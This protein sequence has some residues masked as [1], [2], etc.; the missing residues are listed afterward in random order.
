MSWRT[1]LIIATCVLLHV[2][3]SKSAVIPI[4]KDGGDGSI[5][6][7]ATDKLFMHGFMASI[8]VIIISELG[9]KTFFIAAIL[10]IDNSR[11]VVYAGA[12]VAL[13][14]MTILSGTRTF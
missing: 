10:S 2:F 5:K 7:I 11:I 6:G 4:N 8:Y 3:Y 1:V 14:T 12:M 9:D 13:I